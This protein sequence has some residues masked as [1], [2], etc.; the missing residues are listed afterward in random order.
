MF[1]HRH[2]VEG[3][4]RFVVDGSVVHVEC[5]WPFDLETND[6]I[7]AANDLALEDYVACLEEL[8]VHNRGRVN[9]VR[10]GFVEFIGGESDRTHIELC[11]R[12]ARAPA[13]LSVIVPENASGLS[14][15]M[16]DAIERI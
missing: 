2:S 5:R 13:R 6:W 4:F 3:F 8:G 16:R 12:A 10:H 15:R 9:G 11:D 1:E 7:F 14:R